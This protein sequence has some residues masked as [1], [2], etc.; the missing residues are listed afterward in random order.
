MADGFGWERD[1]QRKGE[2]EETK[3]MW[4]VVFFSSTSS[5]PV[6]HGNEGQGQVRWGEI[7]TS[8]WPQHNDWDGGRFRGGEGQQEKGGGRGDH[9]NAVFSDVVCRDAFQETLSSPLDDTSAGRREIRGGHQLKGVKSPSL[10]STWLSFLPT[11]QCNIY[12]SSFCFSDKNMKSIKNVIEA[13]DA[14]CS[15]TF[16]TPPAS[17]PRTPS[18][19]NPFHLHK[20]NWKGGNHWSVGQ[21]ITRFNVL[22]AANLACCKPPSYVPYKDT[23]VPYNYRTTILLACLTKVRR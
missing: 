1:S 17:P 23:Y 2:W 14:C 19:L 8:T 18:S 13:A 15:L 5:P 11:P 3:T 4:S 12:F 6:T 9:D 10:L 21:D 20:P 16:L 7:P 22:R